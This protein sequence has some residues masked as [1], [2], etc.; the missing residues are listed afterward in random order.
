MGELNQDTKDALEAQG[1]IADDP[2]GSITPD[3][4]GTKGNL[5]DITLQDPNDKKDK[6][7]VVPGGTEPDGGAGA[8]GDPDKAD[9]KVSDIEVNKTLADAGYS[10]DDLRKRLVKDNGI[11]D[12]FVK[13][14]KEKIDPALVDAHVGR[15]RAEFNLQK[16]KAA[17]E[18]KKKNSAVEEMNTFIYDS[19]GGQENFE[20]MGKILKADLGTDELGA[21]NAKLASG[22]KIV[23]KEGL[24]DAVKKYNNIRGMGGKLMEGDAGNGQDAPVHITKEEYRMFMRTEKYK[25][26]PKYAAQIDADRLKTRERDSQ[27]YGHG[28]YYGYHPD[29]GRYAL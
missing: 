14:L 25:T 5:P 1:G 9:K 11:S 3:D 20:A 19:V 7:I 29:K 4:S 18:F 26:D 27:A 6:S 16:S 21:L 28:A 2:K 15:L 24:A 23:I 8:P 12:A 13:E 10:E 22:N 17:E